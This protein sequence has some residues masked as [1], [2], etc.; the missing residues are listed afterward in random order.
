MVKQEG[1]VA[2]I[3]AM[4]GPITNCIFKIFK[5]LWDLGNDLTLLPGL[6]PKRYAIKR[7]AEA[8]IYLHKKVQVLQRLGTAK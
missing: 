1:H 4:L 3:G 6:E 5:R 2:T 8:M 7:D